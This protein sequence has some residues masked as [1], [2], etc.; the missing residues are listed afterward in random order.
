MAFG[1]ATLGVAA[2]EGRERMREM[3]AKVREMQRSGGGKI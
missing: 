1:L 3:Q 2:E